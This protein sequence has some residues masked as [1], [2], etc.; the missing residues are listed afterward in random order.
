MAVKCKQLIYSPVNALTFRITG[1]T[2]AIIPHSVDGAIQ[3]L[4]TLNKTIFELDE[5][6]KIQHFKYK[7][8]YIEEKYRKGVL[9]YDLSMAKKTKSSTFIMPMLGGSRKLFFWTRLFLNCFIKIEEEGYCISL[10]YRQ[11]E[12]PLFIKFENAISQFKD[13][14]RVYNP[15][16]NTIMFIFGI[17]K[18]FKRDFKHFL[19]GA[20]SKL[21]AQ[22]KLDILR[23]HDHFIDSEIGQILYKDSARKEKMENR[24]GVIFEDDT[25]LLSIINI[26]NETFKI[27]KYV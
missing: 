9:Y 17:P 24:L 12:D 21:S 3:S 23:F 2:K 25:E 13:F 19:N 5:V 4:E 20:Y 11:S 1:G 10:L 18:N 27:E 8:N 16:E 26:E 15:T 14:K 22:Y 7:V 6:V